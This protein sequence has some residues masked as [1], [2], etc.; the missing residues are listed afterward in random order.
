[1][2]IFFACS[3]N[4]SA[5]D[6]AGTR[7]PFFEEE[8]R[9]DVFDVFDALE[10]TADLFDS[11]ETLR[12]GVWT[13]RGGLL[14]GLRTGV[15]DLSRLSLRDLAASS[16]KMSKLSGTGAKLL[17]VGGGR[18]RSTNSRLAITLNVFSSLFVGV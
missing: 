15:T 9:L 10:D 14:G 3:Q 8:L 7:H 12:A 1:L 18:F 4:G 5:A 16:G 6:D 17:D 2:V 11:A 13:L